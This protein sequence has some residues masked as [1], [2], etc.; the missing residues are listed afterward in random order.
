MFVHH[1]LSPATETYRR[2]YSLNDAAGLSQHRRS[3]EKA[4]VLS[5]REI[6]PGLGLAISELSCVHQNF[7]ASIAARKRRY[8]PCRSREGFVAT[9]GSPLRNTPTPNGVWF[10][11]VRSNRTATPSGRAFLGVSP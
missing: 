4:P 1:S 3:F 6:R 10:G 9:G 5:D 8:G 11:V 2:S 7:D